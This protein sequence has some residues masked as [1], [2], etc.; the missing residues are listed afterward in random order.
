MDRRSDGRTNGL[1]Q[2]Y[3][4]YKHKLTHTTRTHIR[5]QTRIP[6]AISIFLILLLPV[7]RLSA[8]FGTSVAVFNRNPIEFKSDCAENELA[9]CY[10]VSSRFQ[11]AYLS[12]I[13]LFRPWSLLF[14]FCLRL[15]F[16]SVL[17]PTFLVFILPPLLFRSRCQCVP[18]YLYYLWMIVCGVRLIFSEIFSF[19]KRLSGKSSKLKDKKRPTN[20]HERVSVYES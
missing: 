12:L 19:E 1:I 2:S 11:E 13:F 14:F 17:V 16:L 10:L 18:S 6:L 15:A 8:M 4:K 20:R 7:L 3:T 5:T 9:Q